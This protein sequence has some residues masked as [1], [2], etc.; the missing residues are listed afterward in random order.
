M[1]EQN[2]TPVQGQVG[3]PQQTNYNDLSSEPKSKV[4]KGKAKQE[5]NIAKKVV[6]FLFS[7]KIDSVANYLT[8]Y[9]LG[10]SLRDL[11]FKLGTGALQMAL[12]GGQG[13]AGVP[14]MGG[15]GYGAGYSSNAR[16]DP[17]PYNTMYGY[18]Q[19]GYG[20]A[21]PQVQPAVY[22]Q[23]ITLNDIS[24]DSRDDALLVIDRMQEEIRK[25]QK[26]RAADFY[27][28]AGITG[29]ESNWTLQSNG[30]Y[31]LSQAKPLMRTDGRWM[32]DFPPPVMIK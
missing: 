1:A 31:D 26:V 22:Q 7:D 11:I 16:R 6:G 5:K 17:V 12:Y 24:F 25:Y 15:Y 29:Q 21:Q 14:P 19:A 4:I 8:W 9:V 20:Y 30:W 32:I 27:T 3:Q 28:F 18:P 2:N 10:P 13:G 23:R